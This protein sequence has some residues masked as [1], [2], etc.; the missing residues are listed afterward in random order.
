MSRGPGSGLSCSVS[1]VGG[2]VRPYGVPRGGGS[3][4]PNSLQR[5]GGGGRRQGFN[6]STPRDISR[7]VLFL[8]IFPFVVYVPVGIGFV[9]LLFFIAV[10]SFVSSLNCP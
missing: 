6:E 2:H 8:F 4:I 10:C 1:R 9:V 7:H 3:H 5:G